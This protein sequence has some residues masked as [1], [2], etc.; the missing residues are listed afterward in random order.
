MSVY[1]LPAQPV[2]AAERWLSW[3]IT[4]SRLRERGD[5]LRAVSASLGT[6]AI[7]DAIEKRKGAE[8]ISS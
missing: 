3:D 7:A 2:D 8:K 6:V 5:D 4:D 1:P